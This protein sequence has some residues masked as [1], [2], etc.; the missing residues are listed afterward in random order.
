MRHR[1]K[2]RVIFGTDLMLR[3]R[4]RITRVAAIGA[5][6]MLSVGAI[7]VIAHAL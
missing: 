3:V 2:S 4:N 6:F 5:G 7:Q 1:P